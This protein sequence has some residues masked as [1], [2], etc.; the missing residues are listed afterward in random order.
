MIVHA[1]LQVRF[2]GRYLVDARYSR[3]LL[4]Q[5]VSRD[6]PGFTKAIDPLTG[7]ELPEDG[8]TL[9]WVQVGV[10]VAF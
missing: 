8:A 6:G 7:A 9:S 4:A 10:G 5:V 2:A 3:G 1:G